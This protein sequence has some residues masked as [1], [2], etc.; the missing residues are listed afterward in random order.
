MPFDEAQRTA[1]L[2]ERA[3]TYVQVAL[4]GI[5]REFPVMPFFIATGPGPYPTHRELHPA[6]YG[7]FDWHSCVEMHW[8]IVRL[9]RRFPNDVAAEQA[10]ATLDAHLTPENIGTE[11]AFYHDPNHRTLNRP[12]GWGWLLT[13]A[14]ELE[15]WENPD[16]QRWTAA[17]RPLADLLTTN[18]V[19]WLPVLTYPQRSGF[20]P[21][22]A[23]SLSRCIDLARLRTAEGDSRL[24]SAIQDAMARWF[25]DDVDY[26]A[27]YEPDGA[28]FL[29][30]AL[31]EAELISRLVEST[32]FGDWLSQFL[33][34]LSAGD[35]ATLFEPAEVSDP[36]D[37]QIAHLHGLNL[38]RAWAFTTIAARLPPD[39]ARTAP[40]L[41]AA[42]RHAE[43]SLPYVSGSTYMVEHWL[44]AYATL[45][46]S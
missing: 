22:T 3:A 8:V 24:Q 15:T 28:D 6:F 45:L 12:Y 5:T 14:H 32:M 4:E 37:G 2:R 21:N 46:L 20:H 11:I 36:T 41:A 39:D 9:L 19:A 44:A 35:P 27:R 42:E 10:R 17:V 18:L 33:P 1:I 13:L 43:A 31:T 30:P 26:P 34:G 23:F 40:L 29:S 25:W 16:G 7:C 38:S